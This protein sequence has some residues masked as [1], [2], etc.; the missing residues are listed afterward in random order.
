MGPHSDDLHRLDIVK[1]LIDY[2]VLDID[3]AR[4]GAS[5]IAH[6]FLI[7]WRRLVGVSHENIE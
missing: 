7:G 6:Q 3:A 2:S 5:Q 4:A 1:H